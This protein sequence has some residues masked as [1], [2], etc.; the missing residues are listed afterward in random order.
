MI[1]SVYGRSAL[2][3]EVENVSLEWDEDAQDWAWI[4]EYD[5][6]EEN[7]AYLPFGMFATAYAR[8][9]LLGNALACLERE[10][11]SVIHCDTDSVI[12]YGEPPESVELGD[13]LGSWGV[14]SR[15]G[16]IFEGGFKRYIELKRYP[17]QNLDDIDGMAC[18]GIPRKKDADGV[19]IGMWVE[20]LDDPKRITLTGITLGNQH[21]KIKSDWLRRMYIEHDLD[22]DDVITM[23]L[24]PEKVPGGVILRERQHQLSDNM[25]WRFRR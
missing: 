9:R 7:D 23:K 17:M 21:Y 10:P 8:A 1:N 11:D 22:P 6:N 25:V 5:D 18:A 13:H 2:A 19:P 15:P 14:E 12:C 4:S 20:L 16:I 24:I 3:P